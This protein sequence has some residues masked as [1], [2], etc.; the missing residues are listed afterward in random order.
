MELFEFADPTGESEL[1]FDW[2]HTTGLL[3]RLKYL[4]RA[5]NPEKSQESRLAWSPEDFEAQERELREIWRTPSG[6]RYWT[7][8][9]NTEIGQY[10]SNHPFVW[11]FGEKFAETH[12]AALSSDSLITRN[13]ANEDIKHPVHSVIEINVSRSGLMAR[14]ESPGAWTKSCV[15]GFIAVRVIRFRLDDNPAKRT[16]CEPAAN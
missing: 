3:E 12:P 10:A 16:P 4:N 14:N 15:A 5:A 2:M 8:V 13:R 11:L 7:S 1:A 9:N 6:W